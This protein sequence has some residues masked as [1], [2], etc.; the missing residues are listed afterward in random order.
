MKRNKEII[1]F[2][3]LCKWFNYIYHISSLDILHAFTSSFRVDIYHAKYQIW[4]YTM[5]QS[6]MLQTK[7]HVRKCPNEY[8]CTQANTHRKSITQKFVSR[9]ITKCLNTH[10]ARVLEQAPCA[11]A[12]TWMLEW[13]SFWTLFVSLSNLFCL[14]NH[15]DF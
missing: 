4:N 2:V 1:F 14:F 12:S 10:L 15:L 11:W 3:Y 13:A 9:E 6:I 8:S 5:K 7:A